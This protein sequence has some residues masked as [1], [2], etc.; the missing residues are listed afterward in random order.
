MAQTF[1]IVLRCVGDLETMDAR[2]FDLPVGSSFPIGR[3]SKNA[4]KPELL[5]AVHNAFINSPVISRE[6]AKLTANTSTGLPQVY[7]EDVGSMH[8]TL[9]N[10][11]RLV[12]N[13]PKQ[14]AFGDLLQFGVDV[15][16]D[17]E[18]FIAR[19]YTF[20][21]CLM[22]PAVSYSQGFT[23]PDSDEEDTGP[24]LR[25]GSQDNPVTIEDS[26]SDSDGSE[27]EITKTDD[28]TIVQETATSFAEA[29]PIYSPG[30][31]LPTVVGEVLHTEDSDYKQPYVSDV[32]N[33]QQAQD[34]DLESHDGSSVKSYEDSDFHLSPSDVDSEA[35]EDLMSRSIPHFT[36]DDLVV[37]VP[38]AQE[39]DEYTP[40]PGQG[41]FD[42]MT[43]PDAPQLASVLPSMP[44]MLAMGETLDPSMFDDS[45][46]PLPPRPSAAMPPCFSNLHAP[47]GVRQNDHPGWFSDQLPFAPNFVGT[48]Y[49][50]RPS[51][52]SPAPIPGAPL[53]HQF[54]FGNAGPDSFVPRINR[55]P[56]PPSVAFA[57][58]AS[59]LTPPSRRT[60]VSITEIVE[61]RTPTPASL[62]KLK[63]KADDDEEVSAAKRSTTPASA[64]LV[65]EESEEEPHVEAKAEVV[66]EEA[67]T[68]IAHRPKK[69]PRSI[70]KKLKNTATLLGYGAL[71]AVGAVAVLSNLPDTF[72]T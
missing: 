11:E 47:P 55:I 48:N 7:I 66:A 35:D 29:Q 44:A 17:K 23:V 59:A 41:S 31:V 27:P 40:L 53:P 67:A 56:T 12:P 63:R 43:P 18:F 25:R 64:I 14:L 8:G 34:I 54:A 70:M 39:A 69:Q 46:P 6:H 36:D 60:K 51:L 71:G 68:I 32:D 50:D 20:E 49:G 9:V 19:K 65:Q 22:T 16:R 58:G 72:F 24:S 61:E 4:T 42:S 62:N 45:R 52:F 30:L 13:T 26:E 15:N 57:D 1:R 37:D 21:R 3:S 10:G 28:H 5:P 2:E 38:S 33:E